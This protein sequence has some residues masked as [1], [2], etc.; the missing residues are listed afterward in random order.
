MNITRHPL[1]P[2]TESS[3]RVSP[4]EGSKSEKDGAIVPKGIIFEGVLAIISI[5]INKRGC[6]DF[7]PSRL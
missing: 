2:L 7:K 1:L 6:N 3:D 4:E 5:F